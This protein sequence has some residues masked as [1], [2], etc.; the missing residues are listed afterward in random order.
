MIAKII[1]TLI[2]LPQDY[3]QTVISLGLAV[4]RNLGRI[5]LAAIPYLIVLTAFGGF[6]IWNNGVAL[7]RS[8]LECYFEELKN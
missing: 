4:L 3:F 1:T 6:V 5:I 7:G 8:S 2:C